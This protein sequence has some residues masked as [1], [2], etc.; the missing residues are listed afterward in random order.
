VV[1]T[2]PKVVR[3]RRDGATRVGSIALLETGNRA[4]VAK[5]AN[6]LG[7]S[8]GQEL[9]LRLTGAQATVSPGRPGAPDEHAVSVDGKGR[10]RL[11]PAA[12]G[13]LGV[14]PGGQILAVA[15]PAAGTL[16]MLAAADLLQAVTGWIEVEPPA[17]RVGPSVG[18]SRVRGRWT[19]PA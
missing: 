2:Q 11:P 8:Q 13:C 10:L 5:A 15:V 16:L 6:A 14:D 4:N 7:W 9:V 12:V 18:A 3:P 17:D 19:P 1:P